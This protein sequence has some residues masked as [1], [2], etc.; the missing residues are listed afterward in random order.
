MVSLG[1]CGPKTPRE[2]WFLSIICEGKVQEREAF[3]GYY[4]GGAFAPT[5]GGKGQKQSGIGG[6]K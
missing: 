5:S 2:V 4:P 1:D 6:G 3:F